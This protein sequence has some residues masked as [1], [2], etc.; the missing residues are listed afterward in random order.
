MTIFDDIPRT[1]TDVPHQDET[2]FAYLNV[3]AREEANRV[4]IL[5]D[6]WF[7]HY[8]SDHQSG[9]VA[10]FRSPIDDE[11]RSAFFELFLHELVLANGHRV[12][13]VEPTL[14]HTNR[15]P[16]FLIESAEGYR[17]YLE[18][19]LATGRSQAEV[20]AMNRLNRALRAVD[21]ASSPNHFLDLTVRGFPTA[22][23]SINNLKNR[24]REW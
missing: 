19:V 10:R 2:Q 15:K 4:R 14:Q 9:L 1:R 6:S 8:P 24:L 18:A 7:E 3:S 20:A 12:E 13:A 16:D 5:V 17:F 11:H 23:V 22:P 21:T